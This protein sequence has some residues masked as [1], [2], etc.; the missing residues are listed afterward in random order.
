MRLHIVSC[1]VSSGYRFHGAKCHR[2]YNVRT[3]AFFDFHSLLLLLSLPFYHSPSMTHCRGAGAIDVAPLSL[4]KTLRSS[5]PRRILIC[6][7]TRYNNIPDDDDGDLITTTTYHH[8]RHHHHHHCD[9]S[10]RRRRRRPRRLPQ[11]NRW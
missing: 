11:I 1:R 7:K 3:V 9:C 5:T 4:L 8:R 10:R 6:H 2:N